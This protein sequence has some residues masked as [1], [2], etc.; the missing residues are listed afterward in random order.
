MDVLY[1]ERDF[2]SHPLLTVDCIALVGLCAAGAAWCVCRRPPIGVTAV[3][4]ALVP[5]AIYASLTTL[6]GM[7]HSWYLVVESLFPPF[8]LLTAAYVVAAA[9]LLVYGLRRPVDAAAVRAAA[10]PRGRLAVA[11]LIVAALHLMTFWNLDLAARQ[12]LA[13]LRTEAGVLALSVAPPRVPDRDNAALVYQQAFEAMGL[14][15]AFPSGLTWEKP[16]LDGWNGP[17]TAWLNKGKIEFDL[18]DPQVRRFIKR[19]APT[20]AL[21]LQAAARPDCNFDR[22]YGRPSISMLVPELGPLRSA[23]YLLALDA[24]CRAADKDYAGAIEDVN[25]MFRMA[26]HVGND[27]ILI[28]MLVSITI[29]GTAIDTLRHVLASG[30]IPADILAKIEIPNDVSHR[31]LCRRALRMEE[32]FGLATV[33]DFGEGEPQQGQALYYLQPRARPV[34]VALYRMFLLGDDLEA[35]ARFQAQLQSAYGLPYARALK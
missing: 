5:L 16:W 33:G 23:A 15:D 34:L 10:W 35:L 20:R 7:I 22:D 8:L 17:W 31:A 9:V 14:S 18:H 12:R 26:A 19:Q 28:S 32:A 24:V 11:L 30:H 27:P 3:L 4:V 21:L 6:V 29:E 2:S 25:A 13:A 1:I